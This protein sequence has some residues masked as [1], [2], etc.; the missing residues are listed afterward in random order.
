MLRIVRLI[1]WSMLF[2]AIWAVALQLK[3]SESTQWVIQMVPLW[4]LV[5]FGFFSL[6]KIGMSV[7]VFPTC[8]DAALDLQ[9]E[10]SQARVE[11]EKNGVLE[12]TKTNNM[13]DKKGK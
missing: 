10:I 9:K 12:P 3:W 1:L 7:A 8:L 2:V 11:L 5:S 6:G 13:M 4:M